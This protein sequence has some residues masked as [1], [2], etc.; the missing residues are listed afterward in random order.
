MMMENKLLYRVGENK[1]TYSRLL[2]NKWGN[3]KWIS[4]FFKEHLE[5]VFPTLELFV[6]EKNGKKTTEWWSF[7]ERRSDAICWYW[8]EKA[9]IFLEYKKWEYQRK[10]WK[11]Q[12]ECYLDFFN[13]S[14]KRTK[15]LELLNDKYSKE[16]KLWDIDNVNWKNSKLVW[17]APRLPEPNKRLEKKEIIWVKSEWYKSDNENAVVLESED[18][19]FSELIGIKT[20]L[21]KNFSVK[22]KK[23]IKNKETP[24]ELIEMTK[25]TDH[26]WRERWQLEVEKWIDLKETNPNWSKRKTRVGKLFL[27][28]VWRRRL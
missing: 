5:K 26:L 16:G 11:E 7:G 12:I 23:A 27:L 3:E 15:L 17:T 28:L 2:V 8:Q 18:R 10:D 9:F 13:D 14:D 20:I 24:K 1:E 19:F 4:D 25:I 21:P 22:D 6:F